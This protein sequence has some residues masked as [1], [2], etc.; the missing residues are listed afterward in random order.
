MSSINNN[1]TD[2]NNDV[3]FKKHK[4]YIKNMNYNDAKSN[5]FALAIPNMPELVY[6]TKEL[7]IPSI[8]QGFTIQTTPL[9][10]DIK[11]SGDK[12][13]FEELT[14]TMS[15]DEEFRVYEALLNWFK[16]TNP[17][18]DCNPNRETVSGSPSG[19]QN[20]IVYILSNNTNPIGQFTF[21]GCF[22]LRVGNIEFDHTNPID[23]MNFTTSFSVDSFN[24]ERF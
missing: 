2:L 12:A 17:L 14:I 9:G 1:M 23:K 8:T 20:I 15:I 21:Y 24:F 16:D 6:F 3:L 4:D 22:P 5:N 10:F 13:E 18:L 19:K 11:H 7:S